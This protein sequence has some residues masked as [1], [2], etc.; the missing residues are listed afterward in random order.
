[1]LYNNKLPSE[2]LFI[3][4]VALEERFLGYRTLGVSGREM[5][6]KEINSIE[7]HVLNGSK[8]LNSRYPERVITV[9]Y[10][11]RADGDTEFRRMYQEINKVLGRGE[12]EIKFNDDFNNTFYGR[13]SGA[14]EVPPGRNTVTGS[15]TL[16]CSD[17]LK[18]GDVQKGSGRE[19]VFNFDDFIKPNPH[20][21]KAV[22]GQDS[23]TVTLRN[24]DKQIRVSEGSFRK[25]QEFVFDFK[26]RTVFSGREDLLRKL[27][28]SSQF[29]DFY[30]ESGVPIRL[31]EFGEIE[32]SFREVAV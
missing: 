6:A 10:L 7:R 29:E 21:I 15:F 12:L 22:L 30:V 32:V 1:M 19:V 16:M 27:D 20:S 31:V 9:N 28:I 13:F 18:Y 2:A 23:S 17:P 3:N 8:V 11:L 25:G 26:K 4:G 14:E 24:G 5:F